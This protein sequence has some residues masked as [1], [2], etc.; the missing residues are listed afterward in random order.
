MFALR[1][2]YLDTVSNRGPSP[3]K[4]D[5]LPLSYPGIYA[6]VSTLGLWCVGTI[7]PTRLYRYCTTS[8][9]FLLVTGSCTVVYKV[10]RYLLLTMSLTDDV[11][12]IIML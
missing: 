4:G 12:S 3:C 11:L 2:W 9:Y 10:V 5:A 6:F 7:S 1:I 8:V